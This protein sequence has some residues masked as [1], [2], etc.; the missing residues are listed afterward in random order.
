METGRVNPTAAV[1]VV[2]A[3][4]ALLRRLFCRLWGVLNPFV[5]KSNTDTAGNPPVNT[6]NGLG[7]NDIERD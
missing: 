2:L 6:I 5:G 1:Y 3:E 7:T 4:C